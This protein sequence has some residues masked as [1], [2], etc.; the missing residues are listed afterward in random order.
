MPSLFA[1]PAKNAVESVAAGYPAWSGI[2]PKNYIAG[3]VL[4]SNAE[5]RQRVAT[6][7]VEFDAAKAAEQLNKAGALAVLNGMGALFEHG[8][9]NWES[10]QIPHDVMVVFVAHNVKVRDAVLESLKPKPLQDP[11][12]SSLAMNKAPVYADVTFDGAPANGGKFPFVY[13]LGHE[14]TEVLFKEEYGDKTMAAVRKIISAQTKKLTAESLTWRPFYGYV[15]EPKYFKDIEKAFAK[16]KPLEP[17]EA[18]LKKSVTAKDPEMAK[19][20]QLLYD[21]LVQTKGDLMFLARCA[22][23]NSPHVAAYYIGRLTKYWPSTKKQMSELAEKLKANAGAQ[24]LIKIY[25]KIMEWSDPNFTC[26]NAGEAKKIV[27]ELQKM[28]KQ[29][30]PLTNDSNITVQNG[31]LMLDGMLDELITVMPTKVP[32][33]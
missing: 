27:A 21:G 3:R 17:V 25:A 31:A 22:A 6:V 7:V 12:L 23:A 9:T 32:Q 13:V 20:A 29:V 1:V 5:L 26:K 14:G 24:P 15:A 19:E 10:I 18:K 33:K 30:L 11:G 28:K 4:V 8:T 16:G 2:A